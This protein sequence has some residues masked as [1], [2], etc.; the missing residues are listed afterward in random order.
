M[1]HHRSVAIALSSVVLS[2][3][4]SAAQ[5]QDLNKARYLAAN[6]ANCHGTD[7]RS[8]GGMESLAGYDKD[9]FIRN[10]KEFREGTKPATIMHQL[11]KGYTDEQIN[12]L[13]SFFAAQRK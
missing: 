6:C 13:A 10:M 1:R 5:A 12:A 8:V 11:S 2:V 4:A 9:R 3:F 7:G